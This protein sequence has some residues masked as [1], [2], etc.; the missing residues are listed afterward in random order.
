MEI[1]KALIDFDS[2]FRRLL[3][4]TTETNYIALERSLLRFQPS[5]LFW[6]SSPTWPTR[7]QNQKPANDKEQQMCNISL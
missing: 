3:I 5:N 4:S 1:A 6:T 7:N 2:L